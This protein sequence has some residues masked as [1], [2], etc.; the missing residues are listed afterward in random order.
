MALR[1]SSIYLWT[2]DGIVFIIFSMA[3]VYYVCIVTILAAK[4][5]GRVNW[6]TADSHGES[7]FKI[8]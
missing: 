6:K 7:H 1:S 4:S 8:K 3:A 2:C 5:V